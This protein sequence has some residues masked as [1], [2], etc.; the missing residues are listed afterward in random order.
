MTDR[1][2]FSYAAGVLLVCTFPLFG[3]VLPVPIPGGD[4]ITPTLYIN[5]F[6]PG[7]GTG[8]DGMNAD[9]HGITNFNGLVAMGYGVGT[10]T[11]STGR[12][13]LAITDV[14]VYQGEYFGAVPNGGAGRTRSQLAH[15][16]F[17]EI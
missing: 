10:A 9:P 3:Q 13:Y 17:V 4:I 15:G 11:D 12:S 14:R 8:F 1:L 6:F 2:K 5:Q 7:V 16:T